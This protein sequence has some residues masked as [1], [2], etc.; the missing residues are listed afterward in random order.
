MPT[1]TICSP[2]LSAAAAAAIASMLLRS[3]TGAAPFD[4]NDAQFNANVAANG[5]RIL[6]TGFL[7]IDISD[8][9]VGVMKYNSAPGVTPVNIASA[10]ITHQTGGPD[11]YVFDFTNLNIGAGVSLAVTGN[12]PLA[13]LSRGN[14]TLGADIN[15][16][17]FGGIG[18]A[19]GTTAVNGTGPGGGVAETS[20][21]F[22]GGSGGG[23]GGRGGDGDFNS[24]GH[25]GAAYGDL[26]TTLQAG[27][28]G[29][30]GR[31]NPATSGGSGGGALELGAANALVVSGDI[32]LDGTDAPDVPNATTSSGAGGGGSGGGILLHG[33][34]VSAAALSARGGKGGVNSITSVTKLFSGGGGGGGRAAVVISSYTA[35]APLVSSVNLGGG[36]TAGSTGAENGNAGAADLFITTATVPAARVLDVSNVSGFTP[37]FTNILVQGGGV[38]TAPA[39]YVNTANVTLLSGAVYSA[40]SSITGGN[41]NMNG[42]VLSA[43][44]NVNLTN[45][46]LQGYGT[47]VAAITGGTGPGTATLR[48]SAQS[49]TVG[50]ANR[51]SAV[52]F[53]GS[54]TVEANSQLILLSQDHATIGQTSLADAAKLSAPNGTTLRPGSTLTSGVATISGAFTNQG[55]V[56]GP[57]APGQFLTFTDDVDGPGSFAGNVR[58]SDLYSPG[59]SPARVSIGTAAFDPTSSLLIDLAGNTPGTGYDQIAVSGDLLLSGGTLQ[60]NIDPAFTPAPASQFKIIDLTGTRSGIFTGLPEGAL[61]ATAGNQ[62]L[63]ITYTGGDGNDIVLAAAAVPEPTSLVVLVS[64]VGAPL[65]LRS[66]R[67]RL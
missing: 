50:D 39:T 40:G 26:T 33:N 37:H 11:V 2:R 47:V 49:L 13:L 55:T 67:R 65:I 5:N 66:R 53:N 14:L 32:T 28:G 4:P 56:T 29:A 41:W 63:F 21:T 48:A 17:G 64:L 15:M 58:F 6:T 1:R 34:T 52:N 38:A 16:S 20:F 60:L 19:G 27:S 31:G 44:G 7:L 43:V 23:F 24:S 45:T 22:A 59:S 62:N 36:A 9:A 12:N 10:I 8:P 3:A 57:G 51:A 25:G 61:V 30:G 42:G 35:G 46:T 54:I 18:G